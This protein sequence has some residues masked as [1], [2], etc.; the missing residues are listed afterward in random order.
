MTSNE[1]IVHDDGIEFCEGARYLMDNWTSRFKPLTAVHF[2]TG[3]VHVVG[4]YTGSMSRCFSFRY[5]PHCGKE[6]PVKD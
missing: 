6:Y 2:N 1:C 4:V 3:D 5:C